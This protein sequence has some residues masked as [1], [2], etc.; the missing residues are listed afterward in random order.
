MWPLGWIFQ[1]GVKLQASPLM[2]A[3]TQTYKTFLVM[4]QQ[5]CLYLLCLVAYISDALILVE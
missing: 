3:Q 2:P 4:L 1:L 5:Q